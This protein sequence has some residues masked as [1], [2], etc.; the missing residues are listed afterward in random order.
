MQIDLFEILSEYAKVER[1]AKQRASVEALIGEG[2]KAID[3]PE[4]ERI[5]AERAL[6]INPDRLPWAPLK[7]AKEYERCSVQIIVP[8][9]VSSV[10]RD[11]WEQYVCIIWD[12]PREGS[13]RVGWN[14]ACKLME[15]HRD[16]GEP[17]WTRLLRVNGKI[18]FLPDCIVAVEGMPGGQERNGFYYEG[19]LFVS[20]AQ[21]QRY[22]ETD[23]SGMSAEWKEWVKR[24]RSIA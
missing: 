16:A 7:I 11:R 21:G 13:G 20:Y 9:T 4:Y 18:Q 24:E 12:Y 2:S 23:G 19:G 17:I 8:P 1:Q 6:K 5:K 22:Y 3:M 15:K 14:Q 10:E